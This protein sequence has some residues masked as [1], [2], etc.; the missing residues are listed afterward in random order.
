[1]L[2][3]GEDLPDFRSKLFCRGEQIVSGV[4]FHHHIIADFQSFDHLIG[5]DAIFLAEI[6]SFLDIRGR[7]RLSRFDQEAM[8]FFL[9]L[10]RGDDFPDSG[11][12]SGNRIEKIRDVGS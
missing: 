12:F 3:L 4:A 1:M 8:V 2:H 5:V 6:R 9:H 11:D 7:K 10:D